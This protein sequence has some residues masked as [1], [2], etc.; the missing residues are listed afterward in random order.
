M[1]LRYSPIN[2]YSFVVWSIS[3]SPF[4]LSPFVQVAC[5]I[6]QGNSPAGQEKHHSETRKN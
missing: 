4:Q 5:S 2:A 1:Q 3:F 6:Q